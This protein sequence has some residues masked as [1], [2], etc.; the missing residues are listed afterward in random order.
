MLRRQSDPPS[1][2]IESDMEKK[3]LYLDMDGVLADF[4]SGADK[5]SE[6][7]LQKYLVPEE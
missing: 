5:Q 3:I 2:L 6:E 7:V 4:Q 1:F